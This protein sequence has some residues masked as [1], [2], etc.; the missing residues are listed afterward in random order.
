MDPIHRPETLQRD[1]QFMALALREAE[2]AGDRGEVPVGAV[3]VLDDGRFFSAGNSV[4]GLSDPTAHAEILAI[5]AAACEIGNYRL[6][7]SALYSTIEPCIMCMSA[8]IH[9]RVDRVVFGAFDPRWGG[10]GS[11]ASL[12]QDL[13]LNHHPLVTAGVME[14]PCKGLIRDFFRERRAGAVKIKDAPETAD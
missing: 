1:L 5:R 12:H 9:S 8:I 13:R 7:K 3:L 6:V 10:A 11:I 4:I 2:K 14:E